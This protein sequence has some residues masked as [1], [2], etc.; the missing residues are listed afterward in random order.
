MGIAAGMFLRSLGFF[1]LFGGLLLAAAGTPG[2]TR[3]WLALGLYV[4]ILPVNLAFVS[5]KNPV[6]LRE[7]FRRR[8][9][10]KPF[11]KLFAALGLPILLALPVVAGLDYRF[12]W[13]QLGPGL[14]GLGAALI[15]LGD[16]PLLWALST[17][18]HLE[19]TVRIQHD[20]NHRVIT[21]GPYRFVRHP[22]YSGLL[23]QLAGW[24]LVLGSAW[25]SVPVSL[26]G[27]LLVWRTI[28]E[29]LTLRLELD[30]Y[31]GYAARARFRLLPFVW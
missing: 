28:R 16:V 15:L 1:V 21:T 2:W 12:G 20:R 26:F 8:A 22:M 6:L 14:A 30:G 7:R 25:A 5:R 31:Q 24:P 4:A 17:N 23:I 3:A 27:A 29:D 19:G 9:D 13:S 11:D 18:P 10:T